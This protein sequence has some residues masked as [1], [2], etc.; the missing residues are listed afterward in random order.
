MTL[1]LAASHKNVLSV[2][3]ISENEL[4]RSRKTKTK[5]NK[6]K[7]NI[8]VILIVWVVLLS[9]TNAYTINKWAGTYIFSEIL[10]V[11]F[12]SVLFGYVLFLDWLG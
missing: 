5:Q 11:W 1:K 7:Q 10:P 8:T 2:M 6:N 3:F 9:S 4:L 12:C